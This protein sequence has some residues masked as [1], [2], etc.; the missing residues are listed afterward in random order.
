MD[1]AIDLSGKTILVC[2]VSR[3]GIGGATVRQLVRAGAEVIALDHDQAVIDPTLED[4]KALGGS[5][6][7]VVADLYDVAQCEHE[8]TAPHRIEARLATRSQLTR[9]LHRVHVAVRK[10][11]LVPAATAA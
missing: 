1:L 3:G 8:A 9:S 7:A 2:G 5:G 6:H 11:A 10:S 4:V